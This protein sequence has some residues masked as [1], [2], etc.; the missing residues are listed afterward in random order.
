MASGDRRRRGTRST[1]G[2]RRLVCVV[3][4]HG[5]VAAVPRLCSR[6]RDHLEA[7]LWFVDP[8]PVRQPRSQLVSDRIGSQRDRPPIAGLQR[9]VALAYSR[10]ADAVLVLCDADDDCPAK[11][12]LDISHMTDEMGSSGAVMA[13]REYETWLLLSRLRSDRFEGRRVEEIR[14]AKGTLSKLV[15]NYKPTVHQA[16]LTS[17]LDIARTCELSASFRKLVGTLDRIFSR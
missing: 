7:W 17:E 12:A 8:Q 2:K 10:P 9:A 6:I 15:P 4:G 3:E 16:L 13:V 14:D 1:S 11:W 5:D